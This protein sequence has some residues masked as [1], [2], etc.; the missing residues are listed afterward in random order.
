MHDTT[1][2]LK[3]RRDTL[4]YTCVCLSYSLGMVGLTTLCTGM[5]RPLATDMQL[6]DTSK[7][8]ISV[9]P[10]NP[11]GL[12]RFHWGEPVCV[13]W[14]GPGNHSRRD[15]VGIYPVRHLSPSTR[16]VLLDI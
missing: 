8:H 13:A 9:V 4:M 11:D 16:S 1:K 14:R 2:A 6:Y 7:Y 3:R 12:P 15:W 5:Y 10:T